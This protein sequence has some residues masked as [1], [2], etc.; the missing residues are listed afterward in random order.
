[1]S[2]GE[3]RM[4]SRTSGAPVLRV[5]VIGT[6]RI[7]EE[8]LRFLAADP[9]TSLVGVCD[10]SP[11]LARY[12]ATRFDA[13]GAFTQY[14][15]ML[16]TARPDVVH[17]LTPPHTH[18]AIL[19]DCLMAGAHVI[20]EKPV[21]PTLEEFETLWALALTRGRRLIEDHNY[22]F[23]RPILRVEEALRAGRLGEVRE[24]EVRMCLGIREQGGR[25]ADENLP[26][27]SH[28]L[29][30]GVLHEFLTH[31]CYL[32]LRFVPAWNGVRAVWSNHGGGSLFAFDDLD[33]L[34]LS[35]LTHA[36]L[37]FSCTHSPDCFTVTVRGT[38]GWA[39]ADLYQHSVTIV[40][41]RRVGKQLTPLANQAIRGVALTR[42]AV[43]GFWN[44]IMQGTPYEGLA[45]FLDR[46]YAALV[47]GDEPPV[48][49]DDMR[50]AAAL[51]DALVQVRGDSQR[52][53]ARSA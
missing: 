21:A 33:A 8:H 9:R 15:E 39:E 43:T 16:T 6:G 22:R 36:R 7:S 24:V 49:Y 25:Y 1:M 2:Q 12:A 5:G 14:P 4:G 47:T 50:G 40:E 17:V 35:G 46:T 29:P 44:K 41:P 10:V 18:V 28:R 30:A 42:A 11:S 23:N 13:D 3:G 51:I 34:V 19:R 27:P 53:A 52:T 31:M 32:A 37:R 45:T 38:K 48:G 26:H 20:V